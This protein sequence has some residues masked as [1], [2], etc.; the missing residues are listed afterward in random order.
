MISRVNFSIHGFFNT[1]L[2]LG[3]A[4]WSTS[5]QGNAILDERWPGITVQPLRPHE[6]GVCGRG[7]YVTR[8]EIVRKAFLTADQR[9]GCAVLSPSEDENVITDPDPK[10]ARHTNLKSPLACMS[11]KNRRCNRRA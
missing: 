7:V 5:N 8:P 4:P 11:S 6:A 3:T 1:L 9:I 10:L 2:V